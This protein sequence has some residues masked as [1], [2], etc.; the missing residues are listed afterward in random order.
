LTRLEELRKR[1]GKSRAQV[2]ADID[3]SERH[4]LRLEHGVTPL[5]RM[6]ALAFARYYDVPVDDI[7]EWTERNGDAA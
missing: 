2:A 1:A 5:R 4:L 7:D 6:H 3:M